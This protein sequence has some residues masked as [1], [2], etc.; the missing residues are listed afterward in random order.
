MKNILQNL[1]V[2]FLSIAVS[3]VVAETVLRIDGRYHDLASQVLR[4]FPAIFEPPANHIDFAK[5]PVLGRPIENR[6]DN[7]GVRNHS[8]STTRDKRNIIGFFGDSF[9]Q[10]RRIDDRLSFTSILDLAARPRA[11]Y[12]VSRAETRRSGARIPY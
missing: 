4:A 6:F 5:H 11:R 12:L 8:E 2:V 7:D 9:T 10:N 3:L 1:A